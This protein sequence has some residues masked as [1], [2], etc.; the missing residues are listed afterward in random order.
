MNE[1]ERESRGHQG[2]G[3]R[4]V[5][6]EGAMWRLSGR[7]ERAKVFNNLAPCWARHSPLIA[8]GG[9]GRAGVKG[10][11]WELRQVAIYQLLQKSFGI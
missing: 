4:V 1:A 11:S 10:S 6:A 9:D 5:Q 2:L 3:K 7:G 8:A